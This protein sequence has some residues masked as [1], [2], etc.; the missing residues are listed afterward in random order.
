MVLRKLRFLSNRN[1]EEIEL[2]G[3]QVQAQQDHG[4]Q[5]VEMQHVHKLRTGG[6][7]ETEITTAAHAD[8]DAASPTAGSIPPPS[9]SSCRDGDSITNGVVSGL[10]SGSGGMF[11]SRDTKTINRCMAAHRRL[12][13]DQKRCLR[14][15]VAAG[16]KLELDSQAAKKR[17]W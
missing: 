14:L 9:S 15:S 1:M 12:E 17:P 3:P 11:D 6:H 13:E 16:M 8:A 10:S 4:A 2:A 7:R 5:G